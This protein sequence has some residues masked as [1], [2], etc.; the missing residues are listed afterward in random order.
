MKPEWAS[1]PR[2][3]KRAFLMKS[4]SNPPR[5]R[6]MRLRGYDYSQ[7]GAY[8]VTICAQHRKCLFGTIIDGKMQLNEI[9]KIVVECWNRISQHFP[10]VELGEYVIMPNHTHGI[11]RWGIPEMKSPYVPEHIATRRG[12]RQT[13]AKPQFATPPEHIATRRGEVSSPALNNSRKDEAPSPTLGKIVAY[14]KYQSTKRINQHRDRQGTRIW[15]RDYYDHVVRDAP[16]LQRLCQY[17]Q[18]NPMKWELDQ[19]HPNNPS[20]W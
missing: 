2:P 16:D 15:Q 1:L 18:N 11:I 12:D 17:I 13:T 3:S 6:A 4:K 19:L 8:F 7:P 20:R 5:R 14:F 10:S 9:G